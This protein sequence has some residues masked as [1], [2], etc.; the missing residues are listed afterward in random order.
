MDIEVE[1]KTFITKEKYGELMA[2]FKQNAALLKEDYQETQYFD[3]DADVRL[4]LTNDKAKIKMKEGDIHG[5][6]RPEWEIPVDKEHFQTLELLFNKLGINNTII[7][8]RNRT[9]FQWGDIE[10]FVD[11]NKGYGYILEL[12]KKATEENKEETLQLLKQKLSEFNIPITP[13]EEWER[14]YAHYAENWREL[15]K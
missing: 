9:I 13:L 11:Y 5:E 15:T 6:T 3:C 2:F 4:Q 14:K 12:E 1:V 10:A 8:F 7:W